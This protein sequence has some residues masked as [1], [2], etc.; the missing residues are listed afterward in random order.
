MQRL[1]YIF[2]L[3]FNYIPY[4]MYFANIIRIFEGIYILIIM[5][6]ESISI[7]FH[8]KYTLTFVSH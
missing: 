7:E 2:L 6:F 4:N 5:A 8:F 3:S 1:Q